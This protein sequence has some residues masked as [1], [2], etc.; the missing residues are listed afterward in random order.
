MAYGPLVPNGYGCC[1]NPRK[2]DIVF[3]ISGFNSC[4]ETHSDNFKDALEE[5]LVDMQQVSSQNN[6]PP[7]KL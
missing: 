3:G 5:S 7:S 1:Y 6:V 2:N 4:T